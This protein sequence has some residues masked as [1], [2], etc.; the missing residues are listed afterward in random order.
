MDENAPSNLKPYHQDSEDLQWN[1]VVCPII[2]LNYK[3]DKDA[4]EILAERVRK[5]RRRPTRRIH[6]YLVKWKNLPMEETSWERVKDLE[7]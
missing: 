6:E 7:A 5:G 2:D 3:E 4:E 1:V